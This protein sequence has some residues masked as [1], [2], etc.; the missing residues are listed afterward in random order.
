MTV[1]DLSDLYQEVILD[2]NRRPR[3]FGEL[4]A[5]NRTARGHNPLCGDKVTLFVQVAGDRVEDIA[6]QGSG[7]AISMAAASLMTEALKGVP[8]E[9]AQSLFE[10]FH[11][12]VTSRPGEPVEVPAE[13]GKLAVFAGV[14][15]YP[16]RVKCATLPWH[17]FNAALA[18]GEARPVST[19]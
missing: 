13:L 8:V 15:D 7:C 10:G 12:L 9:E 16:V 5:A 19:E 1:A 17:T 6:F 11:R 2:H 3:N 18:G 4:P 14:R